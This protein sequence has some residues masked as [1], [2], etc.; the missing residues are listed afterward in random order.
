M[1]SLHPAG[2]LNDK[3]VQALFESSGFQVKNVFELANQYWPR[4]DDYAAR[5]VE[6]PWWLVD[7]QYGLIKVGPRKRVIVIDWSH[8]TEYDPKAIGKIGDDDVTNGPTCVHAWDSDQF[9]RFLS[10]LKERLSMAHKKV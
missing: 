8:L 7:T 5:I 3:S 9:A 10:R 6:N 4:V 1:K 2:W